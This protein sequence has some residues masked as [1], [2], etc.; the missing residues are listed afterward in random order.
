M[1]TIMLIELPYKVGDTVSFKLNSGEELV[2][3]LDEETPTA[4]RL[5]KPM[6]L[7]M[8]NNG[9][10]LAPFMF[11]ATPE[12]KFMLQAHAVSCITKTETEIAKQYTS[13]TSNIKLS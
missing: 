12:S 1:D 4:Y 3:R 5:H 10:G 6:C 9:L 11:G 2:A 8:Q 13:S 7:V